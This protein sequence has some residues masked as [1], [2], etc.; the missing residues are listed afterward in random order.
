MKV[1]LNENSWGSSEQFFATARY[2]PF[3]GVSVSSRPPHPEKVLDTLRWALQSQSATLPVLI[4]D[5][6]AYINYRAFSHSHGKALKEVKRNAERHFSLW[7]DALLHLAPEQSQRVRLVH[8][9]EIL[10]PRYLQQQEDVREEFAKRGILYDSILSLVEVFIRHA[11]KTVTVERCL[12]M[13]EY[14]I[15]ELP[16]LLFG[17]ELDN[18]HY[19]M[20]VYPTHY[21]TEMQSLI[22]AI[23]RK[24][25][26][27]VFLNKLR[28][29]GL[30]YS[31]IIQMII[32]EQY[33]EA[34]IPEPSIPRLFN[35]HLEPH[36]SLTASS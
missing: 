35:R 14:V 8:W 26:F 20:L 30:E 12:G 25:E 31:K 24:P 29:Q 6:I 10:T 3:V 2:R 23:R 27:A 32:T 5:D 4:A 9:H 7:R 15:Q 28:I 13:A 19:Q 22:A 34:S 21:P 16:L 17:I 33:P 11:G 1:Y 36:E 18:V